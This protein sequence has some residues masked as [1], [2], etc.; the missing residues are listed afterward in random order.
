MR[1]D[2]SHTRSALS[3]LLDTIRSCKGAAQPGR[4]ASGVRRPRMDAGL[5]TSERGKRWGAQRQK[6]CA[7]RHLHVAMVGGP[8]CVLRSLACLLWVEDNARHVVQVA[9]QRVHLP[10]L[11]VCTARVCVG[12]GVVSVLVVVL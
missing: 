12:R 2:M 11:G 5:H 4:D 9:A 7:G 8:A 3:S 1:F 10:G 6:E